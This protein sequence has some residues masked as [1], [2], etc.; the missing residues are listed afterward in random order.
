MKRGICIAIDGPA[1]SGKSTVAQMVAVRFNYI[2]IDTGAMYRALTLKA[3][4]VGISLHDQEELTK[5]ATQT[6]IQLM[7]PVN[8]EKLISQVFL[9]HEEVTEAI[10]STEVTQRVSILSAV[11]GVRQAMVRLQQGLAANGG[12]VMDG[13]DI[14]TVVLPAA[15]LKIFLTA[16]VSVRGQRRWLELKAKGIE[17]DRAVL[18][19]QISARDYA[20]MHREVDPLL[21]AQDAICLD[22]TEMSLTEVLERVEALAIERGASFPS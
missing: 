17:V 12:V 14:G 4:R 1:G 22:T 10:R 6:V 5:L 20:D 19:E 11:F 9:D 15:E 8:Q 16:S 21:Q 7:A 2:Y 3:L 18:E 13:R